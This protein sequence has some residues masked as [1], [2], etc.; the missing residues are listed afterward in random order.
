MREVTLSSQPL[1]GR[2]SHTP[3]DGRRLGNRKARCGAGGLIKSRMVLSS[4]AALLFAGLGVA[5]ASADTSVDTTPSRVV[6]PDGIGDGWHFTEFSE[7]S[8]PADPTP[9]TV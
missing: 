8:A 6:V 7:S 1:E 2:T 9:Q 3:S 5:G 4:A